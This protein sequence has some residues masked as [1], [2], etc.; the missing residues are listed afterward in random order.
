MP[1]SEGQRKKFQPSAAGSQESPEDAVEALGRRAEMTISRRQRK[2]EIDEGSATSRLMQAK[3][4]AQQKM[5]DDA[6]GD[7]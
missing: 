5:E 7:G 2:R 3:R 4:R 1:A 6:K